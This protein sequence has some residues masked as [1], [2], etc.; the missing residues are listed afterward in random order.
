[1]KCTSY[2]YDIKIK[3]MKLYTEEQVIIMLNRAR[4]HKQDD[5]EMFT[6]EYLLSEETPI[7]LP[8]DDEIKSYSDRYSSMHEDVSD[9]LGKYVVSA[10]HIDGANWMKGQLYDGVRLKR[11]IKDEAEQIL[12]QNKTRVFGKSDDKQFWSDQPNQNK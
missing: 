10:I 1:M 3:V 7:E 4:L 9:K 6:N 11:F 5:T 2:L 8:S 12:N